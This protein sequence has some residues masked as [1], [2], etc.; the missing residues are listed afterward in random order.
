MLNNVKHTQ[1]HS[2]MYK[3]IHVAVYFLSDPQVYLVS[4]KN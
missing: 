4:F 2:Y 1:S 3:G